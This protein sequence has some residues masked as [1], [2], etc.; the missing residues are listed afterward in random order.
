M[1]INKQALS[2]T[3]DWFIEVMDCFSLTEQRVGI[4]EF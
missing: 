2:Q 4:G 1:T 3:G